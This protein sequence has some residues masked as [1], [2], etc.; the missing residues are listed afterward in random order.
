[1]VLLVNRIETNNRAYIPKCWRVKFILEKVK[2]KKQQ[3]RRISF[4]ISTISIL[5]LRNMGFFVEIS[6]Y[7]ISS[8]LFLFL[9][10]HPGSAYE[11]NSKIT[12]MSVIP[13]PDL[14]RHPSRPSRIYI[15]RTQHVL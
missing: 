8:F 3:K 14:N 6:I 2:K 7:F 5:R 9:D 13:A 4:L 10:P 11:V 12:F 15:H 1:V